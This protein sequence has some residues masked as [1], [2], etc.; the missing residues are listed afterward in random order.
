METQKYN[1]NYGDII[2]IDSPSNEELNKKTFFVKFINK[3][4]II[5]IDEYDTKTIDISESGKILDETI[6]NILLLHREPSPSYVIQNN[7]TIN[8]NI[9]ITFGGSLPQILNGIVTNIEE[10]MIEITLIPSKEII[11]IDFAY[12]GIPENLNIEKIIIKD[13]KEFL[14]K[15]SRYIRRRIK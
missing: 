7:I 1:L 6:D 5:L 3:S 8:K 15:K 4:K 2:E 11:Y 9:S 12:S 10:D 14:N 13:S